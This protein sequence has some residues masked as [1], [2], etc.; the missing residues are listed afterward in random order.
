MRIISLIGLPLL[1]STVLTACGGA[2]DPHQTSNP[3][4]KRIDEQK[5]SAASTSPPSNAPASPYSPGHDP[6]KAFLEARDKQQM[7]EVLHS[8]FAK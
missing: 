1:F 3:F 7:E 6:F 8:S 2:T 5:M 4:Q